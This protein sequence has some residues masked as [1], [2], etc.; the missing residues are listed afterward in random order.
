MATPEVWR[1]TRE[2]WKPKEKESYWSLGMAERPNTH[3]NPFKSICGLYSTLGFSAMSALCIPQKR[4]DSV[5]SLL[6]KV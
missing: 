1:V 2:F 3:G 6:T 4:F 5:P